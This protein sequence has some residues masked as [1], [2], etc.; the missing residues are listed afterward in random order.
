MLQYTPEEVKVIDKTSSRDSMAPLARVKETL[1]FFFQRKDEFH[2]HL[3]PYDGKSILGQVLVNKRVFDYE[4]NAP[5][6]DLSIFFPQDH[7]YPESV[8]KAWCSMI[9]QIESKMVTLL[10]IQSMKNLEKLSSI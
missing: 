8:R 2:F 9:E 1:M 4:H 3:T 7:L 5:A 6:V 10:M